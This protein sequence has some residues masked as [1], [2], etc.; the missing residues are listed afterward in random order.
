MPFVTL[1]AGTDES[2]GLRGQPSWFGEDQASQGY[3]ERPCLKTKTT[4]KVKNKQPQLHAQWR[5]QKMSRREAVGGGS[6]GVI[7]AKMRWLP[8]KLCL[9]VTSAREERNGGF[10]A[11]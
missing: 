11:E 9:I 6:A 8:Q 4:T 3:T 1:E 2:L 10:D 5:E 7:W